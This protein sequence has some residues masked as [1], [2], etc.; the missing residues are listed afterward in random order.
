MA[1][2]D[3]E[4]TISIVIQEKQGELKRVESTLRKNIKKQAELELQITNLVT[5]K[6]KS[7]EFGKYEEIREAIKHE[8]TEN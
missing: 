5:V 7:K 1:N 8:A 3:C 2:I 6:N 4:V